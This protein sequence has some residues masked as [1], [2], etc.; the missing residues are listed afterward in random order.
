M[1]LHFFNPLC[2]CSRFNIDHVRELRGSF[3]SRVDLVLVLEGDDRQA[4]DEAALSLH[5]DAPHV[6]DLDGAIAQ[7]FGVYATPQAVL[8]DSDR[9][10][11]FRGNY[12][13]SR[14]CVERSTQFARRALESLT[15]GSPAPDFGEAASTAWG[16][17][18]PSAGDP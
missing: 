16:C 14:Y 18:L 4:L 8:L 5:V 1:W 7:R 3:G 2:P 12:N 9:R 17:S 11:Y 15:A 13:T 6:C 10:L